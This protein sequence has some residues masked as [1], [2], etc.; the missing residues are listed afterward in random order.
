MRSA[1]S[2]MLVMPKPASR[3]S[4]AMP[5]PSSATDSRK[6]TDRDRRRRCTD[7]PPGARVAHGV[8]QRLL[9]DA[10]DLAV[11]AAAERRQLAD[12]RARSA[13]RSCGARDRSC[14]ASAAATSSPSCDCGRSADTDRRASTMCVRARSTAVSR[15]FATAGGSE[16][17]RPL[18]RLQLHQDRAESLRQRVVD[19]A[20]HPVALFEHRLPPRL[21]AALLG[22][23]ALV[24]R[25]R[26]LPRHRLE[27]RPPP[28][29]LARRKPGRVDSA[30]QPRLRVGSSSGAVTR[31]RRRLP[32]L[33]SLHRLG[34]PRVVAACI[35]SSR[36]SPRGTSSS[37]P[38]RCR[39]AAQRVPVVGCPSCRSG[40]RRTPSTD[41]SGSPSGSSSQTPQAWLS[42]SSTSALM[43]ARKKPVMSG[44]RTSRSSASCTASLW[45]LSRALGPA[46]IVD[47]ASQSRSQSVDARLI[48][49]DRTLAASV[50]S[51]VRRLT[52]RSAVGADS[53]PAGRL[54]RL[55]SRSPPARRSG[56]GPSRASAESRSSTALRKCH[57][58]V[59][60]SCGGVDRSTARL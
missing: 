15:L 12:G 22:Q 43:K 45:M 25:Q 58:A 24:Q 50:S 48:R 21:D 51:S 9:R 5:R 35:R 36:S 55:S 19:V 49:L 11:D 6:P 23:P 41:R 8:G 53:L 13:C 30:T 27:Q 29:A 33:N 28:R 16:P 56:D 7:D 60:R 4:R 31:T 32:R 44:S 26:R 54:P 34:Q 59:Q 52:A 57:R 1:R 10:D 39:A 40:R 2:C 42:D 47:L 3:C 17:R 14:A 38:R 37:A 18:R 46:A 20:R